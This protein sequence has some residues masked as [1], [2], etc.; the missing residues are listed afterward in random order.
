MIKDQLGYKSTI[1]TSTDTSESAVSQDM[2]QGR[3][4][5]TKTKSL[6]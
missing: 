5:T 6:Q 2:D 4:N 1:S 3:K